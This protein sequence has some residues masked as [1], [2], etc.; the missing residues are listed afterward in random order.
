MKHYLH[1]R[2]QALVAY[3]L[4]LLAMPGAT[5]A[6]EIYYLEV[7]TLDVEKTCL[8]LATVHKV[9]CGDLEAGL[10]NARIAALKDGGRIGVRAP[11]SGMETPVV[12]PYVLVEDLDASI[13]SAQA[14]GAEFAMLKTDIPGHGAF[15]IYFL[16][17]VQHGLWEL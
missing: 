2:A 10:G 4:L 12:R 7:V 5:F 15:A 6:A 3:A 13:E 1:K 11:L 9:S 17:G 14:A 8:A 16:G